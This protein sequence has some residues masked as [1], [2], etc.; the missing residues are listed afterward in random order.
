MQITQRARRAGRVAVLVCMAVAV[1]NCCAEERRVR[2]ATFNVSLA[3]SAPGELTRRLAS[4]DDAQAIAVA[5]II[6]HVRPDVL[7][8]NEFDY[9]EEGQALSLFLTRYLGVSWPQTAE[10]LPGTQPLSFPFHY[11]GPVNTGTP[12][13]FD[14]D[15][16]GQAGNRPGSNAYGQDCLGFGQ[17]PGQYG[18][19][20]LSKHPIRFREIRTFQRFL[21]RDMPGALLP[22]LAN[23]AAP[24]DWYSSEI[25]EVFRLSSKS[26]WD[27]P[28]DIDA[29]LI[30]VLC[31]HPTPPAFDGSEDRNGRRNHDEIRL[32][33]DYV[34]PG[35]GSYLVDD[36]GGR[37]GLGESAAFV[38]LGDLNADPHDGGNA[39]ASIRPLLNHKRINNI[40]PPTSRGGVQ[41]ANRDRNSE[42]IGDPAE[43]TADFPEPPSGPGNLRVDYAL[44]SA[45]LKQAA[46]GVFW[47]E[48]ED[49]TSQLTG[50]HPFPSSDHRL[51]WVDVL[52]P[53]ASP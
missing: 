47:P 12:T 10:G 38:I 44:P 2:L 20:L 53:V 24:A 40:Q 50:A 23:T 31:S 49:P 39:L 34:T 30:H 52:V 9:D 16:N 46:A 11:Q 32:W 17:F 22:D 6:Q 36:S 18:M 1:R 26:H 45:N 33:E 43:D 7:L 29:S 14:L 25:L 13:G 3:A 48:A 28:I 15:R 35:A 21:W 27:V 4:G 41:A 8:L 5:R 37:G 51:V 42:Q 19:A